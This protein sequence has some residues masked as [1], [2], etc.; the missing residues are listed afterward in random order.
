[1]LAL[2]GAPGPIE[3]R[4]RPTDDPTRRRPDI[5][6]ARRLLGWRPHVPLR[7]GLRATIAG[8]RQRLQAPAAGLPLERTA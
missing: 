3:Y 8:A 4:P 7:D 1:V 6:R 5:R 2:T